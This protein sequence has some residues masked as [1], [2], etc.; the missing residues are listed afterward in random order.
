[1]S[2][3]F[4]SVHIYAEP[5]ELITSLGKVVASSL[6]VRA[7]VFIIA[8]EEHQHL[9]VTELIKQG[10]ALSKYSEEGLYNISDAEQLLATIMVNDMPEPNLFRA[11]FGA[12]LACAR[13]HSGGEV[14]VFGE[15]VTL[16]W[17]KGNRAAALEIEGLANEILKEIPC[18]IYCAYPKRL[19]QREADDWR[20]CSLHSSVTRTDT[21]SGRM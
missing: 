17:E 4:H 16:L 12:L 14:T 2:A 15:M 6:A 3:P 7:P 11:S 13:E 20:V 19:L 5:Q 8:T 10:V 1:M 18:R 9:L 21:Y